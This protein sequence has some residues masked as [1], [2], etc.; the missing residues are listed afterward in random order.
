MSR[1]CD[2]KV[3]V[4]QCRRFGDEGCICDG[5]T[6]TSFFDFQCHMRSLASLTE[7]VD[8]LKF[9]GRHKAWL[10]FPLSFVEYVVMSMIIHTWLG[11]GVWVHVEWRSPAIAGRGGWALA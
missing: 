7:S 5:I 10:M 8:P 2:F 4:H 9:T 6:G 1:L 11:S 3:W